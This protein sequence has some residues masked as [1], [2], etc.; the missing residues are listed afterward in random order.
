MP[1]TKD[2]VAALDAPDIP[3]R[4]AGARD[5]A[6]AGTPE[7]VDRLL[8]MAKGDKSPGVRLACAAAAADIISRDRLAG[9]IDEDTR[10]RWLLAVQGADPGVNTGLFQV[11]AVV[12][13]PEGVNRIMAGLRDPRHDVRAGACVGLWRLVA[14]AEQNGDAA[15]EARVV[16]ALDDKRSRV[17]TRVE[18]AR[19]CAAAG[20]RSALEAARRAAEEA[21]RNTRKLADE[22]VAKL[23]SPPT[24]VGIYVDYGVDIGEARSPGKARGFMALL[25]ATDCITASSKVSR[26]TPGEPLR[27]LIAKLPGEES[28]S[29]AVQTGRQTWWAAAGDDVCAFGDRLV[30]AGAFELL[31]ACEDV[32]G[33]GAAGLRVRGAALLAR[34]DAK[35]AVEALEAAVAGKKVPGDAWWFL[36][37]ALHALGRDD[38]ARPHLEK[39]LSKVAKKAPFVEEARTRLGL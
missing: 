10:R 15:L 7:I 6:L 16:A 1:E 2:P 18:I 30:S 19:I 11:A 4:A 29:A 21:I 36:A 12:S 13:L 31:D 20:Y 23:E 37:D 34:G 26:H 38:E 39:Y 24:G 17:E 5:L 8:A 32:I 9:S 33:T 3:T 25:S 35:G 22:V 14:S 27:V 28:A